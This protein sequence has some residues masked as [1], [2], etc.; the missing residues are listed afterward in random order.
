MCPKCQW[1]S[2][3]PE[4]EFCLGWL[5]AATVA[6]MGQTLSFIL[7][8]WRITTLQCCAGFGRTARVI[9]VD[10]SP[11][12]AASRPTAARC[13]R[14]GSP[15]ST[16]LSPRAT[17]QLPTSSLFTHGGVPVSAA[18]PVHAPL[19]LPVWSLRLHLYPRGAAVLIFKKIKM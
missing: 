11:P 12:S 16:E 8:S 10:T 1:L 13:H 5:E 3:G 18:L 6:M 14:S 7:S 17:Q 15:Q 2:P 4:Q 9:L 19:P